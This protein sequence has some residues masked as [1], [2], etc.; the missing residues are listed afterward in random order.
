VTLGESSR[1]V[2]ASLTERDL[3]AAKR[4]LSAVGDDDES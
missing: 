3:A 4:P 2:R 1:T